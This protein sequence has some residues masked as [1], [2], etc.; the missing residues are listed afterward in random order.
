MSYLLDWSRSKVEA[1]RA[2]ARV[3][4]GRPRMRV[5]TKRVRVDE[6]TRLN[7]PGYCGDAYVY[8]FVEDTSAQRRRREPRIELTIAD[9]TNEIHLEFA[10]AEAGYR[11]NSIHKI[12]TL[13]AALHRF[14]VALVAEAELAATREPNRKEERCRT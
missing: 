3:D 13:L 7:R 10:L 8:V 5:P 6:H 1:R 2:Q 4:E 14:R 12:D 9:C 11:A